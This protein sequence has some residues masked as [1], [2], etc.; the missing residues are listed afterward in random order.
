MW[1][2]IVLCD[3]CYVLSGECKNVRCRVWDVR[4]LG[5]G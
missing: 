3:R 4:D 5:F 2:R 1:E